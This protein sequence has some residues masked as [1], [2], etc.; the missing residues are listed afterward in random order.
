[1]MGDLGSL[2]L[3]ASLGV[4]ALLT[5]SI[6]PLLLVSIV[7]IMETLSVIIQVLSKKLRNGKKVFIIAPVHHHFEKT[8]WPETMV[9]M[10]FWIIGAIGC[11]FG[12]ILGLVS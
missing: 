2:S 7:Y 9:V 3:G 6:L 1:F 5:D 8:G 12:L 11:V 4:I 10:R